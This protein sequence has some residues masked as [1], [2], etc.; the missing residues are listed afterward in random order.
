VRRFLSRFWGVVVVALGIV[1]LV[2][3]FRAGHDD[4]EDLLYVAALIAGVGVLLA[5]WGIFIHL[6][7]SAEE[8]EPAAMEQAQAEDHKVQP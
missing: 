3:T 5:S 8:L 4:A 6:N 2:A 1:G 7:R